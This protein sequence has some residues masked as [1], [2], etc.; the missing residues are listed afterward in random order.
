MWGYTPIPGARTPEDERSTL[1]NWARQQDSIPWYRFSTSG[2]NGADPGEETEAVGD[3][4]AVKSSALGLK[5][6][7]R[8]MPMLMTAAVH[9]AED[10]DD[11]TE[12]YT[13]LIS[14]WSREVGHVANI[15]GGSSSQEKY[16]N[17]PG[18]RFTPY[19]REKQRTA[20]QFINENVFHTPQFFLDPALLRRIEPNGALARIRTAQA[21]VLTSLLNNN[22]MSRLIEYNAMTQDKPSTYPLRQM[23]GDI[24]EGIWTEVTAPSVRIDAFRRNLQYAYLDQVGAKINGPFPTAPAGASPQLAA[25][26]APPPDEARGLLRSELLALDAQLRSATS[27]AADPDTRAHIVEARHRIDVILNPNK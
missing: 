19:S 23:L 18:V 26:F 2:S 20:M 24:R 12:L 11:L 8:I 13:R 6:I 7:K 14:Q 15:I 27:R 16:G 3:A 5:N 22:R 4:D 17:Q 25:T 9:P 21:A 10:N 1:D